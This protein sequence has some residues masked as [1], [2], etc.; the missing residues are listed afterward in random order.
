MG[1][2]LYDRKLIDQIHGK[3]YTINEDGLEI[4]YKPVPD[5]DRPHAMD[6]RLYQI[7][8]K[9][10]SMFA[11]RAAAGWKL[12]QERYRPDKIT[13]DLTETEILCDERLIPIDDDHMIDLYIYRR[14]DDTGVLPL[15]IY[16]HGG[17]M[18]AGDMKLYANQMKLVAEKAHA[19][20]AFP[21]Y[22]LAPECPYP[23]PIRDCFGT[24]KYLHD[25]ASEL[26]IDP[27]RIMV[28][29][30]S[31]GGCLTNSCLLLDQE[32][33][34]RKAFELYPAVDTRNYH[35]VTDY[36]WTYD[37]YDFVPEQKDIAVSRIERIKGG[38][39]KSFGTTMNLYLQNKTKADDPM[40]SLVCAPR[41]ILKTL[42]EMVIVWSEFDFLR[43][44]DTYA[45]HLLHD[46]G[47]KVRA[48]QYCGCDHGFLD[49]LGTVVQAEEICGVMADEIKA[50]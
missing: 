18:T 5:D 14:K 16:L 26:N 46:L 36:Q 22:R 45:A 43:I 2:R 9:K 15:M 50:M 20:V 12:S 30:D 17:G 27:S 44:Q 1:E 4:L 25:H 39:D 37:A 40:V 23:G 7:A 21:E 10:K 19:A 41:D 31:A 29:G 42:P 6:P 47:V 33:W 38:M 24:L 3:Q 8:A 28:A 13:Y 34:I 32:H 11:Q 49:M 35:A 48:I